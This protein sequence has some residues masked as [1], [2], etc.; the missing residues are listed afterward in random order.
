MSHAGALLT[1][2]LRGEWV[3]RWLTWSWPRLTSAM[4]HDA[5]AACVLSAFTSSRS[6]VRSR[7]SLA[8][9]FLSMA[10][11]R[12]CR[13]CFSCITL[14][15]DLRSNVTQ[16]YHHHHQW[17]QCEFKVGGEVPNGVRCGEEC[18]PPI[19]D[20]SEERHCPPRNFFVL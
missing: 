16:C 6:L 20:G 15:I 17:R 7:R 13:S 11:S 10:M 18:S 9:S 4:A 2:L 1:Y 14:I 8:M 19:G 5:S 3:C 12:S